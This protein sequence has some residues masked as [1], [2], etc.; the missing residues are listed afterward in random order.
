MRHQFQPIFYSYTFVLIGGVLFVGFVLFYTII[1]QSILFPIKI[2]INQYTR[3]LYCIENVE[4]I[5]N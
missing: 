3:A 1:M 2:I 5:K 4:T